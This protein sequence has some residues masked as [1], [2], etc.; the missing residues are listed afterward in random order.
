VPAGGTF[1]FQVQAGC[2]DL[3]AEGSGHA[4][5][6]TEMGANVSGTYDWYVTSSAPALST[7]I[8]HNNS[9]E[10]IWY[11]YVSPCT[12]SSWGDDDLGA[13][14]VPAGGTFTFEVPAGCYDLKAEG[15][16]HTVIET[17]M[18]AN[19][20]GTYDW[21]VT[22]SAP[23]LSTI[24]LHNNSGETVW[25][26]YVSPCT[27]STWGDDDLGAYTV[28]AGGTFTFEVP[29]GCYDLKAEGSG[30]AVIE[31]EMGAN[32]S[33]T[34]NWYV[35]S[36]GGSSSSTIILHNNSGETIWYAYVS[37]CTDSTWGDDD[38]GAYTVPNG[39]TFSWSVSAGCYDLKAEG[40]GHTVIETEMGANVS[41]TYNWY[42]P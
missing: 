19:V 14:T 37:P 2:Y 9:G 8:L 10:T 16:G 15:S 26:A 42:V 38:L 12:D 27:D 39:S 33:G 35:T 21:Y 25:Y 6:E 17:E 24:I 5:I 30:H 18:G 20:S 13:Y 22:S 28:P 23:A 3:K 7:I 1:T 32:V 31:T 34:Y 4:V 41:G 29:A 40:S 11:A 36:S